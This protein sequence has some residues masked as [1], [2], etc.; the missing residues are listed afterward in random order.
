MQYMPV[1]WEIQ[2]LLEK[3]TARHDSKAA[4]YPICKDTT[5]ANRE[6][7]KQETPIPKV[8]QDNME[9]GKK[10][11]DQI[12]WQL[13]R[14]AIDIKRETGPACIFQET[15]SDSEILGSIVAMYLRSQ[16]KVAEAAFS[17]LEEAGLHIES[18]GLDD[19]WRLRH[20]GQDY[21]W[22]TEEDLDGV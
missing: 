12:V 10:L 15:E 22:V 19:T 17:A 14:T 7:A 4:W 13:V 18:L 8:L 21:L 1:L 16:R 9:Q 6:T 11:A 3:I 2:E 5:S 20:P